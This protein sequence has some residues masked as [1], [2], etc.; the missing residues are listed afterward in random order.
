MPQDDCRFRRVGVDCAEL[1][2][3]LM[4]SPQGHDRM[5]RLH[6]RDRR[7]AGQR[8]VADAFTTD[9]RQRHGSSGD[10]RGVSS[11]IGPH[12]RHFQPGEVGQI[13]QRAGRFEAGDECRKA[14]SIVGEDR[15]AR[16]LLP[17]ELAGHGSEERFPHLLMHDRKRIGERADQR[18]D[19]VVAVYRKTRPRVRAVP[20]A[21]TG[22]ARLA[23]VEQGRGER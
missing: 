14:R 7:M 2:F 21:K 11:V 4:R 22:R 12:A 6:C 20:D 23:G 9:Q 1:S 19:H 8:R 13:P 18:G 16:R 10:R 17:D 15:R 3:A 5:R